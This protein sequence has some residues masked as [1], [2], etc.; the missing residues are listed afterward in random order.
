MSCSLPHSLPPWQIRRCCAS[1]LNQVILILR[2]HQS[3]IDGIGMAKLL[4][5]YLADQ[6]PPKTT[7]FIRTT[8]GTTATTGHFKP[9]FGGINFTI[10]LVR[11]AIV[12]PLTFSLWIIWAFTKRKAN[13]LKKKDS[14]KVITKSSCSHSKYLDQAIM[15]NTNNNNNNNIADNTINNVN[16]DNNNNPSNTESNNVTSSFGPTAYNIGSNVDSHNSHS[17]KSV[18]WTTIEMAKIQRVKQVT[19]SCLN[20]VILA[21]VTGKPLKSFFTFLHFF[22]DSFYQL[23]GND[24]MIIL[25]LLP[26]FEAGIISMKLFSSSFTCLFTKFSHLCNINLLR[27][28]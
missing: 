7:T 17:H 16:S 8:Q 24:F 28:Q 2:T 25:K 3:V 4:V 11:A 26:S 22:I 6:A 9:R 21:A 18:H 13:Y 19:R 27:R 14:S 1:Y 20:D 5:Q 15:I 23:L 12:G 10:N